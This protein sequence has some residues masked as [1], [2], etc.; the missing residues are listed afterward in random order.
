VERDLTPEDLGLQELEFG[1]P[2]ILVDVGSR[3]PIA[4]PATSLRL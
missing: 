1:V 4:V 3:R 2:P